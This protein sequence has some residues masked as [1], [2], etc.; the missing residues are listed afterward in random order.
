MRKVVKSAPSRPLYTIILGAGRGKRMRSECAKVLHPIA[1]RPMIDYVVAAARGVGARRLFIV[2]GTHSEQIREVLG[3]RPKGITY[4]LQRQ[5]RGTAHA[6]L[7]THRHLRGKRGNVL[8]LNG[9]VP[10]LREDLLRRLLVHH[11]DQQAAI[12]LVSA[13]LGDPAGYGRIVRDPTGRLA[14]IVEEAD[15]S[16]EEKEIREV[17][18]GIYLVDCALLFASLR[19]VKPANQQ[20]ELYLT[21]VV[22]I[23]K[24]RGHKVVAF[25]HDD[26]EEVLG[27]NTRRE[28]AVASKILYRRKAEE[29]M[30]LGVTCIDPWHTYVDSGV[31]VGRDSVLYPDVYLEGKTEIGRRCHIDPGCV[32]RDC[33]LGDGVQVLAHSVLRNARVQEGAQIGPFTHLRPGSEIG[34]GARIG[35]FVEVKKSHI[36]EG[37]RAGHLSYLGDARV[38]KRVNVGAGT[39]TCNYDGRHK[40]QT[41]LEDDVFIGSDTQLVAPVRVCKGAYVGAGSTITRDVPPYSLALSRSPQENRE[42]WVL[43]RHPDLV[44]GR[45]AG[46][47][48]ASTSPARKRRGAGT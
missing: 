39:I 6:V 1:G 36:G 41:I 17:N 20:S 22:R 42:K 21:D 45:A 10:A 37:V 29:L 26:S 38:G 23:L 15:T 44:R 40:H 5:Q 30:R 32:L 46:R 11:R 27:V 24:Q 28:L 35:N 18:C 7:Q 34:S 8:I 31:K 25:Q 43:Q 33:V 47:T 48:A 13:V 12:T 19:Q 9:D 2:L 4:C 14:E 3:G 16:P